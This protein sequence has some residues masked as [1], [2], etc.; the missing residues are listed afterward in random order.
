[1]ILADQP[2][3]SDVADISQARMY[4]AL[5]SGPTFTEQE[6]QSLWL[7]PT[8]R[9]TYF[10]LKRKI[11]A[12]QQ[13]RIQEAGVNMHAFPKAAAAEAKEFIVE[14][15]D[16]KV[17]VIQSKVDKNIWYLTLQLK[18]KMRGAIYPMSTISLVDSEGLE[19]LSGRPDK[20]GETNQ[21]WPHKGISPDQLIGKVSL[22]INAL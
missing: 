18:K 1:M 7:S 14:A 19:W 3:T 21:I 2:E 5:T 4:E 10:G 16:F 12:E 15:D 11:L 8:I 6:K 9:N 22:E 13:A 17:I 20:H